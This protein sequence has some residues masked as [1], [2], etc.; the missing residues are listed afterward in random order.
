MAEVTFEDK[1]ALVRQAFQARVV[2]P[3]SVPAVTIDKD[4]WM[5][6]DLP[7]LAKAA[8]WSSHRPVMAPLDQGS[9]WL[10]DRIVTYCPEVFV[11]AASQLSPAEFSRYLRT[12]CR[13]VELLDDHEG[14]RD[15]AENALYDEDTTG[16][17]ILNQVEC[18]AVST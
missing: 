18:A 9:M 7:R 11:A 1:V 4:T 8:G 2:E 13:L 6:T 10:R 16:F 5:A 17:R 12:V 15:K 14:D 3:R